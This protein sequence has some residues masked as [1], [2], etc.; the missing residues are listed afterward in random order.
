ML[1]P[2]FIFLALYLLGVL[3]MLLFGLASLIHLLRFGF[4]SSTIV[5][6][7]MMIIIGLALILFLSY[8][9]LAPVDW[10]QTFDLGAFIYNLNP[11]R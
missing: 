6:T 10:Q 4:L 9:I 2:Y 1:I 8:Q 3:V 7:T 5:L 11:F